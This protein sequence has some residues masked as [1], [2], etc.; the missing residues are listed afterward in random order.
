[1]SE[2]DARPTPTLGLAMG[3]I[4]TLLVAKLGFLKGLFLGN[5]LASKFSY[6]LFECSQTLELIAAILAS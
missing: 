3:A 6:K 2:S 4:P 1:M 5:L